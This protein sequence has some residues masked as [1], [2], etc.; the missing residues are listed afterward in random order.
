MSIGNARLLRS[1][2]VLLALVSMSACRPNLPP[3]AQ[4]APGDNASMTAAGDVLTRAQID[5][6]GASRM[7]ELF[8]GRF[9][10]VQVLTARGQ[11][12][13]VV[14]G[15]ADPLVVIDG[16]PQGDG[17]AIWSLRPGDIQEIRIL[18]DAQTIS[19]GSRGARGVVVV[20]T[21]TR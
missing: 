19:Y 16:V 2:A 21:R 4:P 5:R 15:Y 17:Q 3:E 12:R 11:S 14:R 20:T 7:T 6:I 1:A 18:R 9:A 8:E 10:G 13:L